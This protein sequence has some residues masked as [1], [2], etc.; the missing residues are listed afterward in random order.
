MQIARNICTK[1]GIISLIMEGL[2][3]LFIFVIPVRKSLAPAENTAH[4]PVI[5][6]I[7]AIL[8]CTMY[9]V[10]RVQI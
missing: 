4:L 8:K 6:A 2:G 3:H 9:G 5:S 7:R 1:L 10:E